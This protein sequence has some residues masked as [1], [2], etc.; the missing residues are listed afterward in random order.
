MVRLVRRELLLIT[1]E[2]RSM[3]PTLHDG[4]RVIIDAGIRGRA[5]RRGDLV[6]LRG[7]AEREG[8]ALKRVA[9]RAGD[10]LRDVGRATGRVPPRMLVVLSDNA[11]VQ[12]GDSRTMGPIPE[13]FVVGKMVHRLARRTATRAVDE[14]QP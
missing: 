1:I 14:H 7:R 8:F 2:G 5:V 13:E 10:V 4:D 12:G 9:G 11:T 3:E 6:L